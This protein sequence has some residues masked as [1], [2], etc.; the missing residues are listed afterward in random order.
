MD[1]VLLL[2]DFTFSPSKLIV[3]HNITT[4]FSERR[5]ENHFKDGQYFIGRIV[6]VSENNQIPCNGNSGERFISQV[7]S[8]AYAVDSINNCHVLLQN[9][10]LG[11]EIR[12][13]CSNE[14][15]TLWTS[16]T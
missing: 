2:L 1:I 7:K 16:M 15:I 8:I 3:A 4:D 9:T 13:D 10:C 11:L 5:C 14:D 12:T 6:T